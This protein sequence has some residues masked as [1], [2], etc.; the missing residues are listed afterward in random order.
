[1]FNGDLPI[2][3]ANVT[4]GYTNDSYVR[5]VISV[6]V[7]TVNF[8]SGSMRVRYMAKLFGELP[9]INTADISNEPYLESL[10][11]EEECHKNLMKHI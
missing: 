9:S 2:V 1:M 10:K 3:N 8:N 6:E 7:L 11:K 5:E 4:V